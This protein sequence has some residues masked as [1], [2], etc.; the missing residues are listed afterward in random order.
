V[1]RTCGVNIFIDYCPAAAIQRKV[2]GEERDIGL[3]TRM[4]SAA[5]Y[6]EA[7]C[8]LMAC[9][10]RGALTPLHTPS[11]QWILDRFWQPRQKSRM[12]SIFETVSMLADFGQQQ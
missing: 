4:M 9:A 1:F 7:T 5:V 10:G 8:A 12:A 3:I 11:P 2:K 6:P